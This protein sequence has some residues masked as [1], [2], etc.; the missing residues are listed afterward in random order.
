M[1]DVDFAPEQVTGSSGGGLT[2]RV[3]TVL[4]RVNYWLLEPLRLEIKR[5]LHV[6]ELSLEQ[7]NLAALK[8]SQFVLISTMRN[9]AFRVPYFLDYYRKL[10]FEHFIIVD[11]ESDDNLR[12]VLKAAPDVTVFAARGSFKKARFG[13]AWVN[14]ILSKYAEGKWVLHV[15]PDEFLVFPGSDRNSIR[16]YAGTL[17]DAGMRALPAILIDM[18]SDR[19]VTENECRPGQNPL[20]VCPYF[21]GDGYVERIENPMSV[22]HIR[23]GP[24]LRLFPDGSDGPMLNKTPFLLWEKPVAYARC[25][26][27]VWPPYLSGRSYERRRGMAGALLHFKFVAE[28]V[29]KVEEE[30][31]RNENC[32]EYGSYAS[33]LDR[34]STMSFMAPNSTRYEDWRSLAVLGLISAPDPVKSPV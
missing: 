22:K 7:D 9:E 6:G 17:V 5:R 16:D 13:I 14:H 28:F 11:N 26:N 4:E 23:G 21:D 31:D 8:K 18:Y 3:W 24:R 2:P 12:E 1:I 10:G 15:D 29:D 32:E 25:A 33:A 19:P 30:L 20:E 27:E 34:V